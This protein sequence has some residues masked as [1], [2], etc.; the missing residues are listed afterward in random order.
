VVGSIDHEMKVESGKTV[1]LVVQ[2]PATAA[3]AD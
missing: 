2:L 1:E 3:I